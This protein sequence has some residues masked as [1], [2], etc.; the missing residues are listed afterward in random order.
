[1]FCVRLGV[2]LRRYNGEWDAGREALEDILYRAQLELYSEPL[3][4]RFRRLWM[5]LSATR[6]LFH[7]SLCCLAGQCDE[8]LSA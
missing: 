5:I 8:E 1:M 4:V 3:L 7:R 6:H 2:C